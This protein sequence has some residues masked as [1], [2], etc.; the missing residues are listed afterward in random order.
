MQIN[1]RTPEINLK[2]YFVK[3][4]TTKKKA[5]HHRLFESNS[6]APWKRREKYKRQI[7]VFKEGDSLLTYFIRKKA[8]KKE[9]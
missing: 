6:T 1:L 7:L 9:S 5:D 4:G 8:L 2:Y 3:R